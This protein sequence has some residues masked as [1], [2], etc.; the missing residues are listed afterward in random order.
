MELTADRFLRDMLEGGKLPGFWG[1]VRAFH[2]HDTYPSL[3]FKLLD[4]MVSANIFPLLAYWVAHRSV[5]SFRFWWNR[6]A[7]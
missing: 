5:V 2:S 1:I 4:R 7:V 6:E 3:G